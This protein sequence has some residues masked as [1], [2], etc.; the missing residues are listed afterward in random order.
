MVHFSGNCSKPKVECNKY[1]RLGH[2]K[3]VEDIRVIER[4]ATVS[5][6]NKNSFLTVRL[7]EPEHEPM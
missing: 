4:D 3:H 2:L 7:M 5:D 6:Y 1:N